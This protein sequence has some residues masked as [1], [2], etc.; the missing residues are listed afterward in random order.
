MK[1]QMILEKLSNASGVSGNEMKIAEVIE[2]S[3]E[4]AC[5]LLKRDALGNI[6]ILKSGNSDI[7]NKKIMI[8]A[9]MD[10]VG[11]M[12]KSIG[13]D[14]FLHFIN[15]GGIDQ[16]TL[17]AQEV[18]VHGESDLFGVIGAKPPHLQRKQDKEKTISM[19]ELYI[20]IGLSKEE[21]ETQVSVGDFITINRELKSLSGRCVTGKALDNRAGVTAMIECMKELQN[22][23]HSVDVYFVATVQEEVGFR[24]AITSTFNIMPDIAIA[25]DV[26]HGRTPDLPKEDTIELAKG[27][28]VALGAN[29]HPKIHE[30]I[31]S[32]AKKNNI[33]FQIEVNPASSGTDAWAMQITQNG[34]PTALLSIPLRYM[35]TS[36]ETVNLNDIKWTGKLLALF[37]ESLN[38]VDW[39]EWLCF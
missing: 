5:D 19:E 36:V 7:N 18:I 6:I 4:Q 22:I 14:G 25:I 17:L 11:L 23:E 35:H 26:G 27:P 28:G 13:K 39:E 1:T 32:L 33:P 21:A 16:K 2:K 29:I 8:G 15:L 9:H 31:A 12:V 38:R 20:D 3:F 24:G 10:E 30:K 34:V 37:I